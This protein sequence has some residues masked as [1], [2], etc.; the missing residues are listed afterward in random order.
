MG[1]NV[2][3]LRS[4]A[5]SIE[6][7]R[8]NFQME[9]LDELGLSAYPLARALHVPTHRVTGIVNGERAITAEG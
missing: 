8:R 1:Q 9:F 5:R 7:A 2:F 3:G 6:R 4:L